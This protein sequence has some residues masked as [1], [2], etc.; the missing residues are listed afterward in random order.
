MSG[1]ANSPARELRHNRFLRNA[2]RRLCPPESWLS[3]W[4]SFAEPDRRL[5]E[6]IR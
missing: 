4:G 3:S 5:L 2:A 6:L 1:Q